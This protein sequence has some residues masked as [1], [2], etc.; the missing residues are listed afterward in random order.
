MCLCERGKGLRSQPRWCEGDSRAA[1]A[2][3]QGSFLNNDFTF[4]LFGNTFQSVAFSCVFLNHTI[5]TSVDSV[6]EIY[7]LHV[8][9]VVGGIKPSLIYR[10]L[11]FNFHLT[12][13][14]ALR[15]RHVVS[16]LPLIEL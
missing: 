1:P 4:Y 8:D 14:Q 16:L 7:Q 6:Q 5:S 3:R 9:M 10:C 13:L 2:W 11:A 12:F 15:I